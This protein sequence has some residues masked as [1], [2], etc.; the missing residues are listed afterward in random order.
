MPASAHS[1]PPS[2]EDTAPRPVA[3]TI[4]WNGRDL[5]AELPEV[6]PGQYQLVPVPAGLEYLPGDEVVTDASTSEV[7]AWLEGRAP[8]PWPR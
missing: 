2:P 7:C 3:R 8:R 4:D 5:P 1:T 6:P